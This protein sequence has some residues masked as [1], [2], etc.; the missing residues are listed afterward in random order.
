MRNVRRAKSNRPRADWLATPDP[1]PNEGE[2][3]YPQLM[4]DL[5]RFLEWLGCGDPREVAAESIHRALKRMS[6][7]VDTSESGSRA[8]IWGIACAL[9]PHYRSGADADDG[10]GRAGGW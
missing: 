7:G 1:D 8:Y 9:I 10:R 6:E 2:L 4:G 5:S 3:G